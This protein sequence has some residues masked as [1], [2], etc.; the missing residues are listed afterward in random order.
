MKQFFKRFSLLGFDRSFSKGFGSQLVWLAGI[1]CIVYLILAGISYLGELYATDGKTYNRFVDILMVLIDPGSGSEAMSSPLTIVCAVLGLIIF[2]GML[3]SVI[4]NVLERRVESFTKGETDYKFSNHVA[5]LGF[6]KSVPSLLEMLH[7]KYPDAYIVMMCNQ[8]IE[9]IRDW[10]HANVREDVEDAVILMNG[11]RDAKDDLIRL[12]LDRKVGKSSYV[13]NVREVY[14]LGEMDET[15]H[16]ETSMECVRLIANYFHP[17]KNLPCY[18]QIN[19]SSVLS[20]LQKTN[21]DGVKEK[22]ADGTDGDDLLKFIPFNF[23]EIWAQKAVA[24][25]PGTD[26]LPLDGGGITADSDKHVHLVIIGMNEMSRALAI[27][28]AQVLHFP[29]YKNGQ[30]C[31]GTT[32]TFIDPEARVKGEEF[33]TR[34]RQLFSLSRWRAVGENSLSMTEEGWHDPYADMENK[35]AKEYMGKANFMDIQW[36]FVE[37]QPAGTAAMNYLDAIVGD[38]RAVMTV[39]LCFERS[40]DNIALCMALSEAVR[41]QANEI[42]IRENESD[43]AVKTLRSISGFS[44]IRAFGM[45]NECYRENLMSDRY[46]KLINACYGDWSTG[47]KIEVNINDS[48]AVDLLWQKTSVVNRYSSIFSGNMLFYKLRSLGLKTNLETLLT[49]EEVMKA[50]EKF[51]V[52]LAMVEHNRWNTEK[53]LMGYR[54]LNSED[55]NQKW[56]SGGD[57][58][59]KKQFIHADIKHFDELS[60]KDIKKDEDVTSRLYLLYNL[61]ID[62]AKQEQ[63]RQSQ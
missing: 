30:P 46:G 37:T 42:L 24:T 13:C 22:K 10:I 31:T 38:N 11:E 12:R 54:P 45:M 63:I 1:M 47:E 7:E 62:Y 36:E 60:K 41:L 18:V 3:I 35:W 34:Y 29:N 27:N 56:R 21:P 58:K 53:L 43:M 20:M 57:G 44:N 61:A 8:D 9:T 14:I 55:E 23:N 25:M 19:S 15:A 59:M 48:A 28:A 51:K 49:E 33:R 52:E 50:T 39:A 17:D 16:D 32:I 6:N 4:S 40:E 26:Y 2:S 5:I